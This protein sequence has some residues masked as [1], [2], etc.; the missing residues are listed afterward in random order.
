MVPWI[1]ISCDTPNQIFQHTIEKI[2]QVIAVL[3]TQR[4]L[5]AAVVRHHLHH[6]LSP[7]LAEN[8]INDV[9]GIIRWNRRAP[10]HAESFRA[11][12]EYKRNDGHIELGLDRE[13]VVIEVLQEGVVHLREEETRCW[14]QRRVDLLYQAEGHPVFLL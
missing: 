14:L 6:L 4:H 2:Q 10:A 3:K 8:V 1:E 5:E 11:V 9:D 12:H 13:A 7:H